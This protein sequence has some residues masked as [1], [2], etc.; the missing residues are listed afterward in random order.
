MDTQLANLTVS[1]LVGIAIGLTLCCTMLVLGLKTFW[2][3]LLFKIMGAEEE[4]TATVDE[5]ATQVASKLAEKST[6]QAG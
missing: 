2:D 1:G 6:P 4:H 3:L 5:L